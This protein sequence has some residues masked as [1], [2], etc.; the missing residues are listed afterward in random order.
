MATCQICKYAGTPSYKS[1]CSECKG[2]SKYEYLPLIDAA[3]R[4]S[5]Y[6]D[7]GLKPDEIEKRNTEYI[8][9]TEVTHGVLHQKMSQQLRANMDRWLVVLPCKI[10]DTVYCLDVIDGEVTSGTVKSFSVLDNQGHGIMEI[11]MPKEVP[12]IVSITCDLSEIGTSVFL[13]QEEAENALEVREK[14][15]K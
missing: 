6:E 15:D 4:L 2:F 13:I 14:Y 11:R 10:G 12:E 9:V 3:N 5:A 8:E 1:P 7:I